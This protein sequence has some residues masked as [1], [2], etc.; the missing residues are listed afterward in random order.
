MGSEM[1]IRDRTTGD[2]YPDD[3]FHY[4]SGT[5]QADMLKRVIPGTYIMEEAEAPAGY[6]KG[7][8]I[9]L[10][11]RETRQVQN[12]ELVDEKI[13]VEIVKTDAAD[14]YRI[15][16]VSDYQEILKTT[17]PKGAYS[18]G[19]ISGAHLVLYKARRNYTTDTEAYPDGYYLEKTENTPASWTVENPE[20]NT[21]V[22]VTAEWITDGKPKYF[23]GIPAG[24]YILEEIEAAG[25]YV[26]NS[27]NIEVQKTGEV[28]TFHMK[29]DHTKLEVF[30]Y[31]KDEYG[32]M[33]PLLS[34]IHI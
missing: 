21:P 22:V 32:S 14:Q 15:D 10:T 29:N 30:K 6:V 8:P 20:D 18:Y 16:I 34:L 31:C 28:Q 1:C 2:R 11:V 13:K 27:M 5:G 26:R 25:G 4:A 19:Q 12:A 33:V 9:G 24:D 23:E 17:E 3:P 7:F